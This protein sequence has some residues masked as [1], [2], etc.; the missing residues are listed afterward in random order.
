MPDA[1]AVPDR[2][3]V[4]RRGRKS[5]RRP[6][7]TPMPR[8]RFSPCLAR[9][10]TRRPEASSATDEAASTFLAR[11]SIRDGRR[12]IERLRDI[13]GVAVD[14]IVLLSWRSVF[15][16]GRRSRWR[17]HV[18]PSSSALA[19]QASPRPRR[20]VHGAS[21]PR[22]SKNPTGSA[23]SGGGITTVSICTPIEPAPAC[24]V[25]PYRR[26]TGAIPR[27]HTLSNISRPTRQSSL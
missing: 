19:R 11:S 14:D 26:L 7:P 22:F 16:L 1:L 9:E 5:A 4:M 20:Y 24:R 2:I 25:C 15:V 8:S 13:A 10:R 27:A 17:D 18:T 23:R 6:P 3:V 12:V 21:A